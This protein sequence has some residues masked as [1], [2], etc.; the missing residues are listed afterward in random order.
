MT[1]FL[2]FQPDLNLLPDPTTTT[3]TTA[4]ANNPTTATAAANIGWKIPK[5]E[6]L[7]EP[8]NLETPTPLN[9]IY[10]T[11]NNF[12]VSFSPSNVATSSAAAAPPPPSFSSE[13]EANTY[14]EYQRMSSIFRA[15]IA[16]KMQ[17]YGD[18]E[19][20]ES[21]DDSRAIVPFNEF[22][23]GSA[24]VGQNGVVSTNRK[25]YYQRSGE[26]V[27]VTDVG[28]D[29]ENYFRDVMK[30]TRMTYNALRLLAML[31]DEK[32]RDI[33][34]Y[35]RK[36][37]GD[38]KAS[39]MMRD[40]SLWLNRDKR[41]VGAIPGISIG[42]VFFWRMEMCVIGLHGQVQAGIDYVPSSQ[43]SNGEPIATSVIVSGGY[44]DDE[45]VGDVI[46]YTGQGGQD[47]LGKQCAHQKL[48]TGN[49]ALER[50]MYYG[51]E[52]R[53][54]RGR[55]YEGSASGKVY[56]YDGIY[57]IVDCWFDGGRSGFGVY[58]FKL[59][60]IPNQPEMGSTRLKFAEELRKSPLK[61]RPNGYVSFDISKQKENVP[62][63]LFNDVDNQQDPLYFDYIKTSGFPPYVYGNIGNGS[64]CE[65]VGGCFENCFCVTKN[66]GEFPYDNNG[67]L[68]KGK[69]LIFECGRH[70]RCPPTCRNRVTQHGVRHRFEVFRSRVT[71]WGVRSLDLIPAGSFICE[72]AGVALTSE[73]AEIFTMNGDSLVYPSRFSDKWAEWGDLSQLFADYVRPSYP[74]VPPLDFALDVSRMRNVACYISHSSAPNAFVQLV[75]YDH[76]N[77]SFPHLMLFALENIP[78]LREI[79]IDYGVADERS[80]KK[81]AICN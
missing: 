49:L 35:H 25:K 38:L 15:S 24:Q 1:S 26:L 65:C 8:L 58:K 18:M 23:N 4:A 16:K 70:C 81:L 2:P 5:P 27:R 48:E 37:R 77:I 66:G 19:V 73:Q 40:G 62:V 22:D 71:S 30:R 75:L 63:F 31:E 50:S 14:A 51:I 34:V 78:P 43:S 60:R 41:I 72:F 20:L 28:P 17:K 46:I 45:D 13:E 10:Q 67:I 76:N 80:A 57:R 42:D 55:K 68:F 44:E 47:K 61:M 11:P 54:V 64:G 59:V 32:N 9:T 21:Q 56:V 12:T 69:P 7:D 74:S 52:V 33:S 39:A 3:S 36:V 79:S 6:P 53:V 29:D